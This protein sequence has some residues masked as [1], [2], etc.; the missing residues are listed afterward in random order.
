MILLG[1]FIKASGIVSFD[2]MI[3]NLASILGE[4]KSQ[5]L[6]LNREAL[7]LGFDYVKE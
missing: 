7:E 2:F 5:L 6:K 3:E 4:G 1:A